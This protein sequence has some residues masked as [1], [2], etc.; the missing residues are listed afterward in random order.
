[1][2]GREKSQ[3]GASAGRPR[4]FAAERPKLAC[5][6]VARAPGSPPSPSGFGAAARIN[7][8]NP[9][10]IEVRLGP[11]SRHQVRMMRVHFECEAGVRFG[12]T[13]NAT[14]SLAGRYRGPSA[15][16]ATKAAR[17]SP[18]VAL[19]ASLTQRAS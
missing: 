15:K 4:R 14:H 12:G 16:R 10:F 17:S 5:L 18:P 3:A 8:D 7:A 6:A 2:K 11:K 1:M 9:W 13:S 19:F